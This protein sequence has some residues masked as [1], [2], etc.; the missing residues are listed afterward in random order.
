[1]SYILFAFLRK[2]KWKRG[3]KHHFQVSLLFITINDAWNQMKNVKKQKKNCN[4]LKLRCFLY[5]DDDTCW[6]ASMWKWEVWPLNKIRGHMGKQELPDLCCGGWLI[7]NAQSHSPGRLLCYTVLSH[8]VS[9]D[10][11]ENTVTKDKIIAA[12]I[13][14]HSCKILSH[15]ISL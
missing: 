3:L 2:T 4:K 12:V 1:M 8:C 11:F 13:V 15:R 6:L 10:N 7:E 9:S 5:I 14:F